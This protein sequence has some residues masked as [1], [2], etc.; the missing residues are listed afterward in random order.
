MPP[1]QLQIQS[2]GNILKL[3]SNAKGVLVYEYVVSKSKLGWELTLTQDLLDKMI[4]MEVC[5]INP[6]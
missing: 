2:D 6:T 4:R 5:K 3:K 1:I